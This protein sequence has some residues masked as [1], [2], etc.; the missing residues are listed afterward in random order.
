MKSIISRWKSETG[1]ARKTDGTGKARKILA[2]MKYLLPLLLVIICYTKKHSE[3]YLAFQVLELAIIILL[4]ECIRSKIVRRTVN[5]VLLLLFNVQ[6]F[7]MIFGTTYVSWVMLSNLSSLEDISGHGAT[8]IIA[9]ALVIIDLFLPIPNLNVIKTRIKEFWGSKRSKKLQSNQEQDYDKNQEHAQNQQQPYKPLSIVLTLEL[10]L[11]MCIGAEFSPFYNVY[12]T[13]SDG[14]QVVVKAREYANS[15][16][17][18]SEFYNT[19]IANNIGKPD[20]LASNPNVILIF[21]EGLSQNIVEDE[22]D[23]TPNIR[24]YESQSLNFTNYYNHTFA[25][26]KGLVGQLYSGY[27]WADGDTNNLISIQDILS[28]NGYHTTFINTEPDN[29]QFLRYLESFEFDELISEPEEEHTGMAESMTDGEAYEKLWEVV[30]EE[31]KSGQPFFTSMYTLGTHASFDSSEEV[32][33]D[34]TDPVLNKFYNMDYQFGRFMEKL[35]MSNLADN[36]LVIFTTDH[37][38]YEDDDFTNAFPDYYRESYECD[39]IPLFFYYKGMEASEWDT[40]GSTSIALAPTILDYLDISAPNY[41][42]G[43]SLFSNIWTK[44]DFNSIFAESMNIYETS[45][46]IEE[47]SDVDLDMI[48]DKLERYYILSQQ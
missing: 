2:L 22:R 23:I 5:T 20:T 46:G 44:S 24:K 32:Y 38:T 8:Y 29:Y 27:S 10:I 4:T 11:T 18:E 33:G 21:T 37:C 13:A 19:E 30:S 6:L 43:N 26:Y 15:S 16:V 45:R 42:M 28:D 40:E 14:C 25:T 36:T 17:D 47:I 48:G 39:K 41:F 31:A 35:E 3:S 1:K 34:G 9:V 12:A 7:V